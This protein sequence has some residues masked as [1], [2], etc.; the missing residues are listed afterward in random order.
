[1]PRHHLSIVIPSRRGPIEPDLHRLLHEQLPA[2]TF[3]D[4]EVHVVVGDNRQGR[5][6]NEGARRAS[7]DLMATMDDDV[8]LGNSLVLE[9]LVGILDSDPSIGMTG[10]SCPIPADVTP[11]QRA[12]LRQIPR[13]YS[14]V[15]REVTDSDMVQHGCLA[16]RRDL[17]FEVG[18][19]DEDLLRGLDPIIRSR[20]RALGLRVVVA[21][22]TWFYHRPPATAAGLLRMYFRNGRG[23]AFAAR[24]FPDRVYELGDGSEGGR[25]KEHRPLGYR[26]ARRVWRTALALIKGEWV[27][28]SVDLSYSA[29]FVV[30][31]LNREAPPAPIPRRVHLEGRIGDRIHIWRSTIATP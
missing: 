24:H 16:M 20:V 2:Q 26:V 27:R 17:F 13:R 7:G 12:A 30:E 18:G 9:T 1:M 28:V 21:P 25:F 19:E 14:R 23:S 10:A 29:G 15:V 11:F 31:F 8:E 6:I 4:F 22:N 5:A 3:Q